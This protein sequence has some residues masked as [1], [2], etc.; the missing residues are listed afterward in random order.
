[1]L[2]TK[3]E[4][5]YLVF[6]VI[7]IIALISVSLWQKSSFKYQDTTDYA[8]L[9]QQEK[10]Q[11]AAYQKYLASVQVDPQASQNLFEQFVTQEDIQ[12]EVNAELKTSQLIVPPVIDEKN[13]KTT[14]KTGKQAIT[15]YLSNTLGPIAGFNKNT[16]DLNQNVFSQDAGIIDQVANEFNQVFGKISSAEVPKEALVMQKALLVS[17][18][19]YGRFLDSA[20]Q[21]ASGQN[22]DPWPDVYQ[23]YAIIN[24]NFKIYNAELNKLTGKYKIS[25]SQQLYYAESPQK[26]KSSGLALIPTAQAA[27][28]VGDITVVVGDIPSII[29]DTIEQGLADSFSQFMG[30]FIQKLVNQI[31]S[32]YKI[33]N[34]LYYS[35][36]LINGQYLDDY[37]NKY[38]SDSVDKQMVKQ[39]I[40][41]F[42]C[43]QQPQNLKP[44]FQAKAS[45]YLGFDPQNVDPKDPNYYQKMSRVGDFMSTPNGWDLYYQDLAN[46]AESQ[47]EKAAQMEMTSSGLK[48]P[49]DTFNNTIAKSVNSI[50][51]SEDASM[52]ALMQL[53]SQNAKSFIS[54]FI[55]QLTQTLMNNFVFSGVTG[56]KGQPGVFKEQSTCLSAA[57][58]QLVLPTTNT[59]YQQPAPPPSEDQL[60]Q[61][62][63]AKYPQACPPKTSTSTSPRG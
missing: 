24:D 15:E 21:Y 61:Q 47:A 28:G 40:P 5:R 2:E 37:L 52:T 25:E 6:I 43:G 53:G 48:S 35:D 4:K 29:K 44:V 38:V 56:T 8:K 20:Q 9:Q 23:N 62:Q 57:Q 22:T 63:C 33:A 58:V 45:Q 27:L 17:Y 26:E 42:N 59:Q 32:N 13:I 19:A 60:Y 46:Q 50:V 41:Q 7:A 31:E 10:V 55:A 11:A 18:A 3:E 51:A 49:R 39:F 34:F 36:A 30:A 14:S 54:G 16:A 1:M 12:K